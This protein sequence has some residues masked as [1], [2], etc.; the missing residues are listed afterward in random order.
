MM[1]QRNAND[2]IP[3]PQAGQSP[4]ARPLW[5]LLIYPSHHHSPSMMPTVS[6]FLE[7]FPDQ[8]ETSP[9]EIGLFPDT[10]MENHDGPHVVLP[11]CILQSLSQ[12]CCFPYLGVLSPF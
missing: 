6:T 9:A 3:L 10:Q 2:G 11:H 4:G 12:Q 7:E 8:I 5:S 1:V